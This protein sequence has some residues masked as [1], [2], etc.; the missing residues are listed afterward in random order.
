MKFRFGETI[1]IH[2][3]VVAGRDAYGDDTFTEQQI[4]LKQVPVVP[5]TSREATQG[6]AMVYDQLTVLLPA[7]TEISSSD[8]IEVYGVR[9]EVLGR[10]L[11][12]VSPFS[13]LN[14]GVPVTLERVTG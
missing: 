2:R 5:T 4:V 6:E 13:G 1:T 7:G 14:L 10:P 9:Y 8:A 11:R 12:F 3:R